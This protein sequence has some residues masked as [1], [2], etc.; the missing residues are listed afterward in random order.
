MITLKIIINYKLWKK[1]IEIKMIEATPMK[2][3]IAL[4]H[5]YKIGNHS[6]DELGYEISYP[7]GYKSWCPAEE[8][9]KYYYHIQDEMV[10]CYIV[11]I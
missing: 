1:Y 11:M 4:E 10:I 6:A 8:F 7:D 3:S 5:G 9:D 2:A